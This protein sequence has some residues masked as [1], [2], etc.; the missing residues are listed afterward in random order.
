MESGASVT[1]FPLLILLKKKKRFNL[2][3]VK[4]S[5]GLHF[6]YQMIDS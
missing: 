5:K 2:T 3:T 1:Q 4:S 6:S